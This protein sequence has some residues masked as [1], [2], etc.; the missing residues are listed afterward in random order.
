MGAL[1]DDWTE[2]DV[3]AVI[4]RR[5][6]EELLHVPIAVSLMPPGRVWAE[7]ICLR[8]STHPHENVRGNAILGFGHLARIFRSLHRTLVEPLIVA[9]LNDPSEY[10]RGQAD[11]AADDVEWF[12]GWVLP[13]REY[14]SGQRVCRR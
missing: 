13:G 4:A 7:R 6:P 11:A 9:G 5:D 14:N 2:A 12:I 1:P 8:L 10:V 3:E